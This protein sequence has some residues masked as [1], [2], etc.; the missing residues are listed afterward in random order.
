MQVHLLGCGDLGTGV[1]EVLKARQHA[2][3]ALRRNTSALPDWL[4]ALA[5]DYTDPASLAQLA[6]LRADVTLLTPTPPGRDVDSYRL[7]YLAPVENLLSLWRDGP[8]RQLIYVS[9]TRVYGDAGGAWHATA[10]PRVMRRTPGPRR[11]H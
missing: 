8:P 3:L 4:P 10:S 11:G 6:D 7:G 5:L 9:S 2:P 1:A